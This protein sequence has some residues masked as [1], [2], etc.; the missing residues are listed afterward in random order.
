[1]HPSRSFWPTAL[2]CVA[3]SLSLPAAAQSMKP[4]LWDISTR[5]THSD[6]ATQDA[7]SQMQKQM[8]SV[9]AEQRKQM[10]AMMAQQGMGIDGKGGMRVKTC[11]TPEQAA[12]SEVPTQDGDC[13]TSPAARS[14]NTMKFSYQCTD[15]VVRGEGTITFNDP[16][17]YTMHNES[18]VTENGKTQKIVIDA[19]GR[20]LK[21]DCTGAI[22][23]P[24]K[25]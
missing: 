22:N 19:E 13:K 9:S 18:T 25:K 8:A 10:E 17:S 12:R 23:A 1:M 6:K 15:P 11:V 2:L 5:M 3:T 7:L 16:T 4:G 21:D 20:W 24:R 14:G